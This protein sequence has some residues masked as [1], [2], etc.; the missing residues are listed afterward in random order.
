MIPFED[1][2]LSDRQALVKNFF[3]YFVDTHARKAIDSMMS[4]EGDGNTLTQVSRTFSGK[5]SPG[6]SSHGPTGKTFLALKVK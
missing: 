6:D 5:K 4:D 3:A 1:P 2:C